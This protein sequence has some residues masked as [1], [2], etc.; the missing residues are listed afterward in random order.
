MITKNLIREAIHDSI[1]SSPQGLEK[2]TALMDEWEAAQIAADRIEQMLAGEIP[3]NIAGSKLQ[4]MYSP[5]AW[6]RLRHAVS[7]L[8][9]GMVCVRMTVEG[10]SNQEIETAT[11]VCGGS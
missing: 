3:L 10:K 6:I 4:N 5:F 2:V 7:T 11:G 1:H 9:K 8:T